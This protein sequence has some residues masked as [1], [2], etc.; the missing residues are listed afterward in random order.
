ML[1]EAYLLRIS[2]GAEE[3]AGELHEEIVRRIIERMMAR[4]G[5][6]EEY[7][8]TA[9]DKW[10]LETLQEA[11]Y[12]LEDIQREIAAKTKLEQTEI[13][14]A[15]RDAGVRA[16]KY[17]DAI[18]RAAGLSPTALEQ[19]PHLTR[20]LQRGYEATMGEWNNLTRTTANAAQQAFIRACDKAY[21]LTASGAVSYTEAVRQAIN[22]IADGGVDVLWTDVSGNVY[23]RD[24]IE[25]ATLRA[26]RTGVGQATAQITTARM[27]EMGWDIVLVSS[28]MGARPGDGG[29]N[30]TNHAWWQGKFYS[31]TGRD[32]R[33]PPLSV[34]GYGTGEG[35]CGWNCRHSFGP[36]DGEH[37]PYTQYDTDEN[38][39]EYDLQQRQRQLER[40][41]RD[42][43]RSVMGKKT[44]VENCKDDALREKA[45][46]DYQRKAALL[47][48]QNKAYND[49]CAQ[50]DL[51]RLQDRLAV[52]KW[53]R[54]QAAAASGA[55]RKYENR[56]KKR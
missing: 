15:M 22:D 42:T 9:A 53:D 32:T 21:N 38:R 43:K 54:Q 6:G 26:V 7:L 11:G 51:K 52:A 10:Q 31:R 45:E 44:A 8:L 41:I 13:A 55:A 28:H 36:G 47:G 19:S 16:I 39:K 37:N 33:F 40:R 56:V 1:D 23:H 24:T 2:E 5:R 35:L 30:P 29:E 14:D 34:T 49:F 20:L 17:D 4:I 27:E 48:K 12:L 50:N 25:T 3:I 18:Y 46:R